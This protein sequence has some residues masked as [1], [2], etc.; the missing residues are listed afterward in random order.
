MGMAW[1]QHGMCELAFTVLFCAS[2]VD[3]KHCLDE[4]KTQNLS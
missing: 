3:E 2:L 1:E 4:I